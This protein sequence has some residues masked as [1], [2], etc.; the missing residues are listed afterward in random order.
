MWSFSIQ[1]GFA[2]AIADFTNDLSWLTVGLLGLMALS[3]GMLAFAALRYYLAEKARP[4]V[5][6]VP[7][8]TE[9]RRAA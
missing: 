3:A 2:T 9:Y 1:P 8:F 7:S 6:T 5:E 4:A